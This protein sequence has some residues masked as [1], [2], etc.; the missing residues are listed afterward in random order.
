MSEPYEVVI[1]DTRAIPR[2]EWLRARQQGIGA[3]DAAAALGLSPWVSPFALYVDK[4]DPIPDDLEDEPEWFLRGRQLED[5]ICGMLA[6]EV[7]VTVA[8]PPIMV[9]STQWPLM[10][11]TP[12]GFTVSPLGDALV[13]VKNVGATRAHEWDDGPPLHY[14]LQVQ[15]GMA[16]T[17]LPLAY[18]AALIGGNK[19]VWYPVERDEA[20][21]A[22][23]VAGEEAFWSLVIL[24][25]PPEVDDSKATREALAA[26]Y[27]HP[28][29]GAVELPSDVRDLLAERETIKTTIDF[30]K[31]QLDS[32]ENKI[33]AMLG[34][35]EA[36]TLDGQV[37]VTWRVVNR[38]GYT[39][40]PTSFR[41]IGTPEKKG[42]P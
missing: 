14:R 10:M 39:V 11:L 17:G 35:A 25:R 33:K 42:R 22:D 40:K 28:T 38:A 15:H 34:N 24:R 7:G 41:Q 2:V 8:R 21:I 27:A 30:A 36:G 16:V 19:F 18:L 6:A 5:A 23:I 32:V 26:H 9:R 4:V 12:D 1:A 20:M 13:E 37:V 3:S 29:H 31:R